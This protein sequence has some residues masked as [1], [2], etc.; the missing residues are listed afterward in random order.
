MNRQALE[1]G[2]VWPRAVGLGSDPS[3]ATQALEFWARDF[4]FSA[5]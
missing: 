4:N 3:P 2:I 1:R 5:S